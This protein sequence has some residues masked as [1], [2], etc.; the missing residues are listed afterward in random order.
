M[1]RRTSHTFSGRSARATCNTSRASGAGRAGDRQRA[2]STPEPGV[3][4]IERRGGRISNAITVPVFRIDEKGKESEL[5]GYLRVSFAAAEV[6]AQLRFLQA[7]VLFTC[8]GVVLVAIP[9]A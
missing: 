3:N 7:M 4:T 5:S 6:A 2:A 1:M 9:I 8:M